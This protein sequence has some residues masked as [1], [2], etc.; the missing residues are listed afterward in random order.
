MESSITLT[1]SHF[2]TLTV[3]LVQMRDVF[4]SKQLCDELTKVRRMV[5]CVR[6]ATDTIHEYDRIY[7]RFSVVSSHA[8]INLRLYLMM[9]E[10][11]QLILD[12]VRASSDKS[13]LNTLHHFFTATHVSA[14]AR[15]Y[16]K[17]AEGNDIY[18]TQY[19]E[20]KAFPQKEREAIEILNSI[21]QR[22]LN[23]D[24]NFNINLMATSELAGK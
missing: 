9:L 18:G 14:H 19:L 20:S 2:V 22:E 7:Q 8:T 5:A 10:Y 1:I 15:A 24:I 17:D 11:I 6:L 12:C 21:A 23:T 13:R 3:F 16:L 4:G